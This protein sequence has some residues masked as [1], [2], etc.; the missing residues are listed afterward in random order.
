MPGIDAAAGNLGVLP[1]QG[2]A[3]LQDRQPVGR[4][5]AGVDI[6]LHGPV[7]W[8]RRSCTW[9]TPGADSITFFT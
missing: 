2:L 3:H 8:R 5:P 6:H 7:G 9:P 1:R 4:Q